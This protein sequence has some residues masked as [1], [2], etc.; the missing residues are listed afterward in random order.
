MR[1]VRSLNDSFY[2]MGTRVPLVIGLLIGTTLGLSLMGAVGAQAGLPL[3]A[4]GILIPAAVWVGQVWRL[5]TWVFFNVDA[6]GLIF[7]CLALWWFGRDLLQVWGGRRFLTIYLGLAG[8][9]GIIVCLIARL[10]GE[11]G[12]MWPYAGNWPLVDALL[13]AWAV[14]FPN[15]QMLWSFVLPVGG[16]Q[17]IYLVVGGTLIFALM[18]GL[19]EFIPH[20]LAE[21]LMLAYLQQRSLS[22]LWAGWR[23]SLSAS[24]RRATHLR[25]VKRDDLRE[26]PRWLH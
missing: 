7:G 17:L 1:P 2:F 12:M 10:G 19:R 23:F 22:R 21:G 13:I 26:P 3:R 18:H 15:R 9:V 4:A 20:F 8:L 5:V 24:R 14:Y 16:R 11:S 6:L 25:A